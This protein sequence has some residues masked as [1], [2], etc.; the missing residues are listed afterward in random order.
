MLRRVEKEIL[1]EE[2]ATGERDGIVEGE[3]KPGW[4]AKM[5]KTGDS[6]SLLVDVGGNRRALII[7]CMLQGFQQLCGFVSISLLPVNIPLHHPASVSISAGFCF[8]TEVQDL[9]APILTSYQNSLMYFSATIFLPCRLP[10]SNPN[11]SLYC[12]NKLHNDSRC[13]LLHRP[14]RSPSYLTPLYPNHGRRTRTMLRCIQIP[15]SPAGESFQ[16]GPI[17]V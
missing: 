16:C 6:F 10:L 3:V 17:D 11:V 1:E 2:D 15:S 14:R 5:K 9:F 4:R 12:C 8:P 7:A 13:I